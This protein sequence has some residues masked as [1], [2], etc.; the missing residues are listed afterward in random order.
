[1][2]T[3]TKQEDFLL[4]VVFWVSHSCEFATLARLRLNC[5]LAKVFHTFVKQEK[6]KKERD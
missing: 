1:M 5:L 4:L 6:W 2:C 3:V